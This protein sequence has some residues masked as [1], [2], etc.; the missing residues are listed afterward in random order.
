MR[1]PLTDPKDPTSVDL[2]KTSDLVDAFLNQGFSFFDTGLMYH[3][4]TSESVIRTCLVDHYPRERFQIADKMHILYAKKPEDMDTVFQGQMDRLGIDGFDRYLI[5]SVEKNYFRQYEEIGAFDWIRKKKE[6]GLVREIGFSFHDSA[7][8][9]DEVL[10]RYPFFDFV[11]LQINYLDWEDPWIQSRKCYE[12][13]VRHGIPVTVMETVKGGTLAQVPDDAAAMLREMD[14]SASPASWA[15]RFAASLPG[16]ERVLSG[17]G[18]PAMIRDNAGAIRHFVP[19][20]ARRRRSSWKPQRLF[21]ATLLFRVRGVPTV[22]A[23]VPGISVFRSIFRSTTP[24]CG[25]SNRSAGRPMSSITTSSRKNMVRPAIVSGAANVRRPV[26]NT[27]RLWRPWKRSPPILRRRTEN[28]QRFDKFVRKKVTGSQNWGILLIRNELREDFPLWQITEGH[29]SALQL[30]T[31]KAT[32][33][34]VA[35]EGTEARATALAALSQLLSACFCW[36][37]SFV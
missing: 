29:A 30:M 32:A 13:A 1:L 10:T 6:Q 21:A 3:G 19:L 12:T 24:I 15:I 25:R 33:G 18:S 23:D 31:A 35:A 27:C 22:P 11:Q 26:R 37:S 7:E 34:P 14:P 8:L 2:Q 4:G 9:L 20:T 28:E 36:C 17:M 16:V 5:H